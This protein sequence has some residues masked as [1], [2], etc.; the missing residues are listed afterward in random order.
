MDEPVSTWQLYQSLAATWSAMAIGN[1]ETSARTD[2]PSRA[3]M[4]SRRALRARA[5]SRRLQAEADRLRLL[6]GP[7]W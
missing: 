2:D 4:F 7:A 5:H 3:A 6:R 1:E